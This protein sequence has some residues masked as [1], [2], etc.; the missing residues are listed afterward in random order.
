MKLVNGIPSFLQERLEKFVNLGSGWVLMHVEIVWIDVAKYEPLSG[1]SYLLLP[2]ELRDKKCIINPINKKD[3]LCFYYCI[4]ISKILA[5]YSHERISWYKK[6]LEKLLWETM[7]DGSKRRKHLDEVNLSYIP[8]F[9][10]IE[11][12]A[13]NVFGW[14]KVGKEEH[15]IHY[16]T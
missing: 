7:D 12:M 14:A 1:A 11:K 9:E 13:I 5:P 2:K 6:A 8:K 16:I 15:Y 10:K 4:L 3:N